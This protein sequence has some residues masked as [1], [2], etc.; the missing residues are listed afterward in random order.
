MHSIMTEFVFILLILTL[1]NIWLW[2]NNLEEIMGAGL[3]GNCNFSN[4]AIAILKK[5]YFIFALLSQPL[6]FNFE[7]VISIG[8]SKV[9]PLSSIYLPVFITLVVVLSHL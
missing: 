8:L 4:I 9:E 1:K 3:G 5:F 6:C 7:Y 2:L